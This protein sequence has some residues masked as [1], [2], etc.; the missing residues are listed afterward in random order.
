MVTNN[1]SGLATPMPALPL[2]L[3]SEPWPHRVNR[4]QQRPPP[5]DSSNTA[6]KRR[7]AKKHTSK[8]KPTHQT[9]PG[10]SRPVGWFVGSPNTVFSSH[11]LLPALL[12]VASLRGRRSLASS[13]RRHAARRHRRRRSSETAPARAVR[14]NS[15]LL[16]ER[17][18]PGRSTG[19]DQP[20]HLVH[21]RLAARRAAAVRSARRPLLLLWSLALALQPCRGGSL[22][23][24][25]G[26]RRPGGIAFR[27]DDCRRPRL[28][29]GRFAVSSSP[30]PWRPAAG[31]AAFPRR[32]DE[33]PPVCSSG[34]AT[35]AV[36]PGFS[37][38]RARPVRRPSPAAAAAAAALVPFS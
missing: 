21:P 34:T 19:I 13:H 25:G 6:D 7:P 31:L 38:S 20:H 22:C 37:I 1:T 30:S 9:T 14:H 8:Q 36:R 24:G 29:A 12:S 15:S 17:S 32:A 23:L 33:P 5:T 16:R 35:A 4:V 3:A 27:R 2:P 28:P 10:R 11:H 18:P 26:Q